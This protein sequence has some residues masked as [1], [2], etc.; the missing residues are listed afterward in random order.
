[1]VFLRSCA[2]SISNIVPYSYTSC[3]ELEGFVL[4]FHWGPFGLLYGLLYFTISLFRFTNSFSSFI[5]FTDSFEIISHNNNNNKQMWKLEFWKLEIKF[6]NWKFEN[7]L[8]IGV[9]KIKLW[10][11]VL[12][13]KLWKL[14]SWK[15]F[16][17]GT[18]KINK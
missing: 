16:E 3:K 4:V 13:I 10:I 12:K 1:M 6:E 17:D 11:G 5:V 8:R 14:E 2:L 18:L 7:H 15:L 9:L